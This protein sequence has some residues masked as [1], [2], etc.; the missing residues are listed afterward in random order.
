MMLDATDTT[1][2][3]R[4]FKDDEVPTLSL[5]WFQEVH[6]R[7]YHQDIYH[8]PPMRQL[9]HFNNHLVKYNA[10]I[11][12]ALDLGQTLHGKILDGMICCLSA[13]SRLNYNIARHV[14]EATGKLKTVTF[15]D[16]YALIT[17]CRWSEMQQITRHISKLV[18]GWDHLEKLNYRDDLCK[19]FSE[20]FMIYYGMYIDGGKKGFVNDYVNRLT[21]IKKKNMFHEDYLQHILPKGGLV[22][23]KYWE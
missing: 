18:E 17:I 7:N 5:M 8:L 20:A 16:L 14:D 22:P 11:D 3:P 1:N 23:L 9:A 10:E 6:N 4:T 15:F 13:L 12:R 2:A 21:E 19:Y